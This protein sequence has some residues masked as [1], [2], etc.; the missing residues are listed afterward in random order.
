MNMFFRCKEDI[1]NLKKKL[2][3]SETKH[4]QFEELQDRLQETKNILLES[5]L[6]HQR[7]FEA[8]VEAETRLESKIVDLTNVSIINKIFCC[9]FFY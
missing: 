2:E 9:L 3:E 4:Q 6:E 8:K 1:E 5:E 7:L